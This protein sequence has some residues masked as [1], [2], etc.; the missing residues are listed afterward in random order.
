MGY[1]Q[2]VSVMCRWIAKRK[3]RCDHLL[4]YSGKI[5]TELTPDDFRHLHPTTKVAAFIGDSD[6]YL[7]Q[8]D[9][10]DF[11]KKMQELFPG[12]ITITEYHGGHELKKEL[13]NL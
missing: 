11:G 13:I 5:P 6:P 2:G 3:I 8:K 12:L 4:L 10:Q 1:S 7:S 9:R